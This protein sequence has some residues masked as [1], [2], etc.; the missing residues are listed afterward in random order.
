M[1]APR[2]INYS[3]DV[4][5][6]ADEVGARLRMLQAS[7]ADDAPEVRR[8]YLVEEVRQALK[9]VDASRKEEFLAVLESRFPVE[10]L[11]GKEEQ[12]LPA[13][14][15]VTP[16]ETLDRLIAQAGQLTAEE[17]AVFAQKLQAAGIFPLP[18][19]GGL[20]LAPETLQRLAL[21]SSEDISTGR[22][23]KL[24]GAMV[25]MI[26]VLDNLI[27][28]LWK[29]A[30][31]RSLYRRDRPGDFRKTIGIYL[32]GDPELST[33]EVT[34]LLEKTRQL[35][36][37]VISAIGP[38]GETYARRHLETYAPEKIRAACG[39]AGGFMG[40]SEQRLW[41]KYIELVDQLNGPAVEKQI[42][43]AIVSYTEDL[44][45]G[46]GRGR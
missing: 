25:E 26:A 9:E 22:A 1:K 6:W 10:A 28:N 11:E 36:A 17:R 24:L 41:R 43:D 44:V 40:V 34:Q 15:E 4:A 12:P 32:S 20:Q 42:V 23:G 19:E 38:A 37:G 29:N 2:V 13:I 14:V 31:P 5:L 35:I 18:V 21:A 39:G 46:A 3:A 45:L 7:F 30:A 33:A 27:W 16:E 8:E